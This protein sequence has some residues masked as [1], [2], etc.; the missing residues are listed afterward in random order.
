[1]ARVSRRQ[2]AAL[3]LAA[4]MG[5]PWR[6]PAAAAEPTSGVVRYGNGRRYRMIH[7]AEVDVGDVALRSLGIWVPV[8][9]VQPEQQVR[10]RKIEPEVPIVRDAAGQAAV[11]RLYLTEGFPAPASRCGCSWP[12][13][14]GGS[15]AR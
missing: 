10:S 13:T 5:M 12:S 2:A 6:L 7:L 9:M 1:M 4:V 8:P 11:A 3:S 14:P 15:F